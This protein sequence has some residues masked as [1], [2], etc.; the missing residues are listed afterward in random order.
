MSKKQIL[1]TNDDGILS[2]GLWAAAQALSTLG[3]VT[4]A[5]PREQYSGAGRSMPASSDG[6]IRE[7]TLEIGGQRWT[8]Y[9]IGGS[10]AQAVLHGMLDIMTQKPDLVVSGINYGENAGNSITISGTVG[11]AMEAASNG[12][13]ALAV[14]L[15]TTREEH[16]SYSTEI[17]FSAAAHFTWRVAGALLERGLPAGADLLKL[18]VPS[19]ATIETPIAWARL[20]RQRYFIP[21]ASKR[22]S[23]LEPGIVDYTRSVDFSAEP[24]DS[25]ATILLRKRQVSLTPLTM[26][27]TASISEE[28][29]KRFL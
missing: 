3:F 28:E 11:A 8:A 27:M 19:S 23:W 4:I 1:L 12:I 13:P 24:D 5:A 18:D 29:R 22:T 7:E 17:D 16:Q 25:D 15:E 20:S 6:T 14:S 10:P 9:A 2:P 21:V 26:D